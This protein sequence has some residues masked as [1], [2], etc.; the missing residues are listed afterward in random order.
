[1]GTR[2]VALNVPRIM[3]FGA[4]LGQICRPARGSL[5]LQTYII[6]EVAL[7]ALR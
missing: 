2:S 6:P 3:P 1:M 7:L 5:L 4:D